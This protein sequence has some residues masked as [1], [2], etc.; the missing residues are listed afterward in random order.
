[1]TVRKGIEAVDQRLI[2]HGF[3]PVDGVVLEGKVTDL[4]TGHPL[5]STIRLLRIE[6]QQTGGYQY[7]VVAVAN[8]DVLGC[9]LF[10][11]APVGWVR[12]VVEAADFV[13]RIAGYARLDDQPC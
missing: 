11:R 6:P 13:P 3:T 2:A 8:S 9:W 10:K 5:A 4:A 1:V 12:V 7:P